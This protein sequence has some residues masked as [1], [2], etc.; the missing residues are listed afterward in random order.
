MWQDRCEFLPRQNLASDTQPL[1]PNAAHDSIPSLPK[2]DAPLIQQYAEGNTSRM[3][4]KDVPQQLVG[5][6]TITVAIELID[7]KYILEI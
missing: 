1:I 4:G 5:S 7:V 6:V 3:S 2:V